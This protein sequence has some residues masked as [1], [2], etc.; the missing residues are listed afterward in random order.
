MSRSLGWRA[1]LIAAVALVSAWSLYPPREK[2]RLGLDLRGGMHLVLRVKTD[3]ALR[4]ETDKDM[5]ALRR[6]A[7]GKGL[8]GLSARRTGDAA[9]EVAG[10]PR[11][12]GVTVREASDSLFSRG[13]GQSPR[14]TYRFEGE[15]LIFEMSDANRAEVAEWAVQQA[16]QTI[17]NR[18]DRFGVSEP[19]IARQGLAGDRLVI[20]LPGVEDPDRVRELIKSTAFLEFRMVDGRSGDRPAATREELLARYGGALPEDVEILPEDIKDPNNRVI[21]QQFWALEKQRVITGRDLRSAAPDRGQ[22]GEPVVRF[23]LNAEG[24]RQFGRVT[25]ENV[26]RFLAIALDGKVQ[27]APRINSRITDSG[28]IEGNYTQEEVQ[29]QVT[30]LRSGALP[31]GIEYLEERTVGASL[32]QD[33]IDKG[34]KAAFVAMVLTI[35][36]MFAVYSL[37][38]FNA[39]AALG[40]NV[41]VLFGALTGFAGLLPRATLTLPGIAGIVLTIGMAFDANVLVFERI[42]EELKA[43][44]AV[45]SAIEAGF[46]KAMSSIVDSNITTMV[47]AGFLFAFGTGPVQGFAV[48]LF[49]GICATLFAGVFFS[50]WLF[51]AIAQWRTRS[52][53]LAIWGLRFPAT[54][55]DFM[56]Y[57]KI[58]VAVSL[59]VIAAGLTAIFVHGKLNFGIDFAG[60]TQLILR[61]PEEP[62]VDEIRQVLAAAGQGDAQIQRYGEAGEHE[63]LIR[64]PIRPG[65]EEGSGEQVVTA[66][67]SRFDDFEVRS[68]ENVGPQVG[69]ELRKKGVLAVLFSMVGM[70]VYIWLRFELRFGVG[71]LMA[72]VHDVLVT[73]GLFAYFGFEFNLTTIA[74]FLTLVGYSVN[75]TVVVFDRVRE[76]LRK[77][78]REPLVKVLNLSLNQTLSRTILTGGTTLTACVALMI[79]GGEVLRGFAFILFIGVIVGT[80]S[81]IY[82]ASPFTLLWEQYLGRQARSGR[83]TA[84]ALSKKAS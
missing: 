77:M 25:G 58:W 27:T 56:K 81:S 13:A 50:R 84:P 28:I 65:T 53:R 21:G 43:G 49:I 23:D 83:A 55:L 17:R 29:D 62:Q 46:G 1:G 47:A 52:D 63:V 18:V 22:F 5:D 80:Y 67:K 71:A 15:R 3:D 39:V 70:L 73:L 9:F 51:D 48:T 8:S 79:L 38:G 64:T 66:L 42:R 14:W 19:Y 4:A 36:A 2:I 74:A 61:F 12:A 44:R 33:S 45:R 30:M 41:V 75:D 57:R 16:L 40:L 76:N 78:R 82:I 7:E 20:Q 60:G 37:T 26:G 34:V 24:A 32:G 59:A 6:A 10:V 69:S 35:L 54:N 68:T 31:A 11:A 72:V